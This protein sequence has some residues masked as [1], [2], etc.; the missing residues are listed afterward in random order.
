[1]YH[2]DKLMSHHNHDT[3]FSTFSKGT[4]E[5]DL[6]NTDGSLLQKTLTRRLWMQISEPPHS[7]HLLFR[8]YIDTC[9]W[10]DL[11]ERWLLVSQQQQQQNLL[12]THIWLPSQGTQNCFRLPCGHILTG[13]LSR[14]ALA[15]F[16]LTAWGGLI[17]KFWG[18]R[19]WPWTPSAKLEAGISCPRWLWNSCRLRWW[20]SFVSYSSLPPIKCILK[21]APFVVL[22]LL[23]LKSNN[24]SAAGAAWPG[25]VTS[26]PVEFEG[27]AISMRFIAT[28]AAFLVICSSASSLSPP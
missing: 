16:P 8:L 23:K 19:G 26:W 25:K 27:G 3:G 22:L 11:D 4:K 18:K 21:S 5:W 1:M 12:W 9:S 14:E 15:F 24:N 6:K 17:C 2:V 10:L 13:F 28:E 7:L 20:F